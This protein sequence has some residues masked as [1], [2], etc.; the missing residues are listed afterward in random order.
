MSYSLVGGLVFALVTGSPLYEH[1]GT[2][3]VVNGDASRS[4]REY[5]QAVKAERMTRP[6]DAS[7]G[8]RYTA[9]YAVFIAVTD[10]FLTGIN[11]IDHDRSQLGKISDAESRMTW[12]EG[13]CKTNPSAGFFEAL[14]YLRIELIEKGS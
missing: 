10:G 3:I 8:I 1:T 2:A 14:Q 12:L 4:C 11:Y 9:L 6:A 13:Y 7:P 5:I